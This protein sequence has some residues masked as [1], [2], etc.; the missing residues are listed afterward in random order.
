MEKVL[1]IQFKLPEEVNREL[2]IMAIRQGLSLRN[3]CVKVLTEH[4]KA[5]QLA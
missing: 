4:A 1:T 5:K 2:K 3:Y